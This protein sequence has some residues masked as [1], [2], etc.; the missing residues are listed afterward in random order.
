MQINRLS[1]IVPIYKKEKTIK[2]ELETIYQTLK[3]T[4]YSFEIIGVVDG[5]DLDNSMEKARE[6]KHKCIKIIG[7]KSNKGKGQAVRFGMQ[8]AKGDIIMFIDSG[9]DI[10][11]QGLI[12]LLE[13]MKW[14]DADIIVG[15]KTH[16]ASK[17]HYPFSRK[18]TSKGYFYFV[19]F[20]FG[21][22]ISDTQ[23]GIKAFKREVLEKVLDKLVVKRFA[24]DIE[25]LAVAHLFGFKKIYEAPVHINMDFSGS[26]ITI[27]GIFASNG[28]WNFVVDTLAVWYRMKILN[29]YREGKNRIKVYDPELKLDVNTGEM[30]GEKQKIIDY[31]NKIS[32]IINIIK[33][34]LNLTK[35]EPNSNA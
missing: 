25:I 24:F 20:L 1:V 18:I 14:Y 31:V 11:P 15:S 30:K 17:V 32:E 9:G 2:A 33:I 6:L 22:K 5:T 21:I 13:H 23:T 19:K 8:K 27:L 28:I 3:Q 12:M 10:D 34:K 29:Y 4:P 7:Y 35:N 16:P 26:T